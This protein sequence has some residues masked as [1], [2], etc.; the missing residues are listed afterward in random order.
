M[1]VGWFVGRSSN[2]TTRELAGVFIEKVPER[3]RVWVDRRVRGRARE[4]GEHDCHKAEQPHLY[5]SLWSTTPSIGSA[6]VKE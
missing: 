3:N 2:T 6:I 1:P 5:A 4:R